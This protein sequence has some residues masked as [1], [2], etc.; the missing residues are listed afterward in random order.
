[1]IVLFV[2]TSVEVNLSFFFQGTDNCFSSLPS[3]ITEVM[4]N[5]RTDFGLFSSHHKDNL[6]HSTHTC[7]LQYV[8]EIREFNKTYGFAT[9]FENGV[10]FRQQNLEKISSFKINYNNGC[11]PIY[12]QPLKRTSRKV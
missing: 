6:S 11:K 5:F 3:E 12:T 9:L 8:Y 10:I 1:M 2:C 7:Q 4:D